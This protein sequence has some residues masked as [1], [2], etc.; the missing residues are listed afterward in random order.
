MN[1]PG[2]IRI[3]N[4]VYGW[5][6][7]CGSFLVIAHRLGHADH[8]AEAVLN[9]FDRPPHSLDLFLHGDVVEPY[10][11]DALKRLAAGF[12]ELRDAEIRL[13]LKKAQNEHVHLAL[14]DINRPLSGC[15][16]DPL[17]AVHVV[18]PLDD[19]IVAIGRRS[20]SQAIRDLLM[21]DQEDQHSEQPASSREVV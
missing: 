15:T 4:G 5:L 2:I 11:L 16:L 6:L 10:V 20:V 19:R 17:Q 1:T 8:A 14:E 21:P 12:C 3:R 7:E 9:Q 18:I 13:V